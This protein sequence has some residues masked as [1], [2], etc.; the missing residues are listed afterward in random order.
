MRLPMQIRP[1]NRAASLPLRDSLCKGNAILR[2]CC[3]NLRA[4]CQSRPAAQTSASAER[5]VP[6]KHPQVRPLNLQKWHGIR[7]HPYTV[8]LQC[9]VNAGREAPERGRESLA[10]RAR[11][12]GTS[13]AAGS[14]CRC[15]PDSR[16]CRR[17]TPRAAA[18]AAPRHRSVR[19]RAP[20]DAA[21]RAPRRS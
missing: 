1:C 21:M 16:Y 19:V 3:V 4:D 12:R 5:H 11:E 17:S 20:G 6:R 13:R 10:F 15:A 14:S 9:H 2:V 7:K 8:P 18:P